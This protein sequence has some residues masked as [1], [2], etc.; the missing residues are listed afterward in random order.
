[1]H[2]R[3]LLVDMIN[4]RHPSNLNLGLPWQYHDLQLSPTKININSLLLATNR[5]EKFT[6]RIN[7][8]P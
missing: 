2:L 1:M 4:C 3:F 5:I 6:E 7:I 8:L